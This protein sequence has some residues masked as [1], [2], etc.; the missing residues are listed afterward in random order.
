MGHPVSEDVGLPRVKVL[1]FAEGATLAHVLRPC[2]LARALDP[3]E[4]DVTL[5]RPPELQWLTV[6]S[7]FRVVDLHCQ[8]GAV[9]SRRLEYGLPLYDF[10][11]LVRYVEEDLALIDELRPE[12][13]VGDFRL[14]L[15]VSARLRSIPYVTICDAYWSPERTLSPPL[16]AFFYT[17][18]IPLSLARLLS[19]V[20]CAPII[21]LHTVPLERLRARYGMPSLGHD[22]R[23]CYTD[24]DL[25]LFANFPLLFPDVHADANAEFV[26]PVTWFP[27]TADAA[28]FDPGD[29]PLI[30]V[31]LG[32]SGNPLLLSKIVP[33]LERTGC[34]VVV[35]TAG[36]PV[37][38]KPVSPSTRVFDYLPGDVVCRKARLVVCNGGSPTTNQ[39][40]AKGVPVLGIAQNMDQ[41]LNMQAV[42]AFG[43]GLLVRADQVDF[44]VLS[45]AV[46][47]LM[48]RRNFR[49]RA[50]ELAASVAADDGAA[51]LA[52]H[53]RRL[54]K[55]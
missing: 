15:S 54:A 35:T 36:K 26:G 49:D 55:C 44:A 2:A 11:T 29:E 27:E 33:V 22:L 48:S 8:G 47:A 53:L 9:F 25:R 16:P 1:F 40:L 39:A 4:F 5:C 28:D 30:Y 45:S 52:R 31:T 42:E 46:A 19:R 41:F 3:V 14:S 34:R 32:S 51:I 17:R 13:I 23:R 10:K 38:F 7:R 50:C 43:A 6:D 20:L 24:A 12:V 21:R 37:S 18:I